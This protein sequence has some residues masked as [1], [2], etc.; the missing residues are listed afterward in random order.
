MA[1]LVP[2]IHVFV[3]T[4]GNGQKDQDTYKERE[5]RVIK[6]AGCKAGCKKVSNEVWCKATQAIQ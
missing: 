2:A 3:A 5:V 4:R 1:G 6:C